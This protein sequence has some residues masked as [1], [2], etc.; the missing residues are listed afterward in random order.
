MEGGRR[1]AG[2]ATVTE[3][4]LREAAS[5]KRQC[6][7]QR[8]E[9]TRVRL[10]GGQEPGVSPFDAPQFGDDTA[11]KP[12]IDFRALFAT[13]RGEAPEESAGS[14]FASAP[15]AVSL[16]G[17]FTACS[18]EVAS[19]IG[20]SKELLANVD[21]E[22]DKRSR[23]A[24]AFDRRIPRQQL[25]EQLKPRRV[26]TP[27]AVR[28]RNKLVGAEGRR[29]AVK[30]RAAQ[31]PSSRD[32]SRAGD[33][34]AAG[35]KLAAAKVPAVKIPV[36]PPLDPSLWQPAFADAAAGGRRLRHYVDVSDRRVQRSK[37]SGPRTGQ[38]VIDT[39]TKEAQETGEA[40]SPFG[41][42]I[43]L[44]LGEGVNVTG[45]VQDAYSYSAIRGRTRKEAAAGRQTSQ[46]D[47]VRN[48]AESQEESSIAGSRDD[49]IIRDEIT[50]KWRLDDSPPGATV[51]ALTELSADPPPPDPGSI[52]PPATLKEEIVCPKDGSP[53]T[54]GKPGTTTSARQ[55]AS[56]MMTG[57]GLAAATPMQRAAGVPPL[58]LH[59]LAENIHESD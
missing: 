1:R 44:R 56:P 35:A 26:T 52:G 58:N 7:A 25:G 24:E 43:P 28:E 23:H 50:L 22:R 12:L 48:D 57:S 59:K 49:A 18:G 45:R 3:H 30:K 8:R 55:P 4:V 19:T 2:R 54:P 47:W 6:E 20:K 21:E 14:N 13:G 11:Q 31:R 38:T 51:F 40:V 10:V 15:E 29:R 32:A 36:P 9:A 27:L 17:K 5:A 41:L 53:H 42:H 33:S 16:L 37:F 34:G 39:L 46:S